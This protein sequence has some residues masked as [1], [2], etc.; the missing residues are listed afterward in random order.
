MYLAQESTQFKVLYE[1]IVVDVDD[2]CIVA[3]SPGAII[4]IFKTK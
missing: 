4:D 3:E 1:Y 2:L